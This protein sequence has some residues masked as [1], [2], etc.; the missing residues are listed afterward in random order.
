MLF[1]NPHLG[2]TKHSGPTVTLL[3]LA[4]VLHPVCG[5]YRQKMEGVI[6]RKTNIFIIPLKIGFDSD[7]P[8]QVIK[9]LRGLVRQRTIPT[10]PQPL[11]GEVSANF[12]SLRYQ[13]FWEVVGLERGPLSLVRI[14]EELLE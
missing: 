5:A 8:S 11:V 10:E 2:V 9:K 6:T 13:I 12:D 14:I 4:V 7:R 1:S 3:L